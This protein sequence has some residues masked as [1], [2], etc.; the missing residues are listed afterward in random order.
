MSAA[1]E[2]SGLWVDSTLLDVDET[3]A[4]VGARWDEAFVR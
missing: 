2:G 4:M 3:V 1:L